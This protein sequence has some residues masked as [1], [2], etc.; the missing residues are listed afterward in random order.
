MSLVWASADRVSCR[1][2]WEARKP[3]FNVR[4]MQLAPEGEQ[5]GKSG[6]FEWWDH[7]RLLRYSRF[8]RACGFNSVQLSATVTS[9]FHSVTRRKMSEVFHTLADSVHE[10]GMQVRQF[11]WGCELTQKDKRKEFEP[12]EFA[13]AYGAVVDD[14]I[15]HWGDPAPEGPFS[16]A[17][18]TAAVLKEYRKYNPA[19]RAEISTW[20]YAGYWGPGR[21]RTRASLHRRSELHCSDGTTR[22]WPT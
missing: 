1:P 9:P 19:V 20:C 8:V 21:K 17:Q 14:I 5:A 7:D 15:T 10:Q 12:A 2:M 6:N 3:F 11:I 18:M 4:E 13:R 22:A 16:P